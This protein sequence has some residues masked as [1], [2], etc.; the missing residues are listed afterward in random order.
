MKWFG[1]VSTRI[2]KKKPTT[3]TVLIATYRRPDS[4]CRCLTALSSQSLPPDEIL[5]VVR[6]ED[7]STHAAL[8][9]PETT[10]YP[11]RIVAVS[12]PG[13]VHARNAAL[14]VCRSDVVAIIDDDT[15]PYPDWLQRVMQAFQVDPEL[16]GLGGRDR[17][18]GNGTFDDRQERRVGQIT[19]YGKAFGNHHLGF[20]G[21]REVDL[22]K[23][24]N[25]SFRMEAVGATRFDVRLKGNGAQPAE[26][27]CFSV[28]I[29]RSG[30]KLCYD[31]AALLAHYAAE[32][33]EPRA[34]VGVQKVTDPQNF[35]D[36]CYNQVLALWG[37]LSPTRRAVFF[38]WSTL[39]GTGVFPGLA[40]A[41][42]FTP[43]LGKH[44][45]S[46]LYICQKT[47]CRA[48]WELATGHTVN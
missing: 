30:W 13:T 34:Y 36:F 1:T 3:V 44:S 37:A 32:R 15:A 6:D 38:V 4:L 41:I 28:A 19:W 42:R 21:I 40:Q 27:Y 26:D 8:Q 46:R 43:G 39:I 2:A 31:P 25:M 22:L 29:K 5:I 47:K 11:I 24:A 17:C 9:S 14:A 20:G 35:S 18:F 7:V 23:G 33:A 48:F 10:R 16:G 45:W 12:A